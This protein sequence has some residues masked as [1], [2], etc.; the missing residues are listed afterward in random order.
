MAYI[1]SALGIRAL[2]SPLLH[3]VEYFGKDSV[4]LSGLRKLPPAEVSFHALRPLKQQYGE[5]VWQAT[6]A[7]WQRPEEN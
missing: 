1:A 6:E 3:G 4:S 2:C 5:A 7:S